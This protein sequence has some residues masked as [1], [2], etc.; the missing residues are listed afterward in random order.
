VWCNSDAENDHQRTLPEVD[1]SPEG[2]ETIEDDT[3]A[4]VARCLDKTGEKFLAN[5]GTVNVAR[6][7]DA[8]RAGLGDE[9]LTYL[10]YSYGTLIGS[11]YAEAFPQ[12]V[13]AMILDV[14]IDPNADPIEEDLRQAR[15]FQGAFDDYAADC[16]KEPACPLGDDPTSRSTVTTVWSTR[17]STNPQRPRIRAG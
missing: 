16:A 14:A 6:D 4:Y 8:I 11:A 17:W 10:G 3:K 9:K 7:L 1:Y 5:V 12:N 2:V 13:R 15:A